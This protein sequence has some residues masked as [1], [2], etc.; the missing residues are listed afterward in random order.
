LLLLI[1]VAGLGLETRLIPPAEL[2]KR[3]PMTAISDFTKLPLSVR[4]PD[5]V[6]T[7]SE[8]APLFSLRGQNK[9]GKHWEVILRDASRGAWRT[10]VRAS[11]TYYF[12]GYPGAAGS[13][14]ATWILALSFDGGGQ[15]VPFFV[16]THGSYDAKG[17]ED[18]LDLDGTGPDLLEQSYW[19]NIRDDPGYYVTT[20]YEQRGFYWSRSDGRHGTHIFPT[21]EKWSVMWK[22]RPAELMTDPP[23]KQ[24][25]RDSSNDPAAGLHTK[26]I[27]TEENAV[28]VGPEVGCENV[29]VQVLVT[30]SAD[31]RRIDLQPDTQSLTTL[32]RNQKNVVLTGLYRWSGSR[33]C[34]ASIMW[35]STVR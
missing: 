14:P 26:I 16:M 35:V 25:V 33:E 32:A 11:R 20:L 3:I 31:G 1:A 28:R 19:G 29:S 2:R 22:D 23:S 4:T 9:R 12:A 5:F 10:D 30:D 7:S 34:D 13:G 21:F 6:M 24:P 27:G 8:A 18:V 17:I 15:P